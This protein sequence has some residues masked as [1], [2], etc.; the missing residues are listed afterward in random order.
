MIDTTNKIF[1]ISCGAEFALKLIGR[2]N[3]ACVSCACPSM[4]GSHALFWSSHP[5]LEFPP[6]FG[7]LQAAVIPFSEF[8]LPTHVGVRSPRSTAQSRTRPL[9]SIPLPVHLQFHPTSVKS[10]QTRSNLKFLCMLS[11][12]GNATALHFCPPPTFLHL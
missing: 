2:K 9:S 4:E 3:C 1:R 7:D 12:E 10:L 6:P 8:P 5:V 11:T